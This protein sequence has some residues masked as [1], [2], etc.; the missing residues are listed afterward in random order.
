MPRGVVCPVE[1]V[2]KTSG[3]PAERGFGVDENGKVK[4]GPGRP[5]GRLNKFTGEVKSAILDG[6]NSA[7]KHGLAYWVRDLAHLGCANG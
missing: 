6:M 5:K 3:N 2:K 4:A 1:K 7:N